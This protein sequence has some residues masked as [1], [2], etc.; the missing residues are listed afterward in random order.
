M[1]QTIFTDRSRVQAAQRCR[2]LRWLEYHE[3]AAGVGLVPARKSSHLVVGSAVHSGMEI[4]LRDGQQGLDNI[5]KKYPE[6]SLADQ[7]I[8]LFDY[9]YGDGQTAARQIEDRAVAAALADFTAEWS[10]G[11]ELDPEEA[12]QRQA[13]A[14]VAGGQPEVVNDF[15][16]LM[17]NPIA[18][19]GPA[20]ESPIVVE[21]GDLAPGAVPP[22]AVACNMESTAGGVAQYQPFDQDQWLKEEMAALVEAMVRCWARRRWRGIHEAFTILEVEREGCWKLAEEPC[23]FCAGGKLQFDSTFDHS[24]KLTCP[25][26]GGSGVEFELHFLSRHDALLHERSTG[27]LYLQSFKTTGSW[28][29][30]KEL[31]AQVDMQGLSEAVDVE[32]RLEGAWDLQR[33][34]KEVAEQHASEMQEDAHYDE[35][36]EDHECRVCGKYREECTCIDSAGASDFDHSRMEELSAKVNILQTR[37][38]ELVSDRTADWLSSLP[39][40]PTVLGV[41]YEYLLKG[42]RKENKKAQPGE[43]RWN[44]ESVLV[45]AY[46]QEG[47][48]SDDRRWAWTYEWK[49]ESGRGRR[50]D[51]RSWQKSPV[52]RTMKVAEWIDL[53]DQGKVQEGALGEDG[54]ELDAL[55]EQLVPVLVQY[56]NRDETLDLLEQLASAETQ[57]AQDV[58]KVRQAEREGGYSSKRSALNKYFPQTRTACSYPGVC[59][60][61]S[62]PTQPGFCF[63]PPDPEHDPAVLEHFRTRVPNHPKENV[64]V[65]IQEK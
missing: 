53:L 19:G 44:Q 27:Y 38:G 12:R 62:M 61:R 50:L 28:D 65:Q 18:R 30:R 48:T 49:D 29:R 32:K 11:V 2:R 34:L 24:V 51:Y 39:D 6:L 26:C 4:L 21:F 37:I 23:K 36:G 15:A 56:R 63:G 35:L 42:S 16:D 17:A 5:S 10:E 14:A 9:R 60:F 40:P 25:K 31:D 57:V 7:L 52:W 54:E 41:R 47:I 59:N 22:V 64:L 46:K 58:E 1:T 13:A 3:G 45:R 8:A 20:A 55:A 33:E 43:P